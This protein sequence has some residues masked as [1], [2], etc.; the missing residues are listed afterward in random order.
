MARCV[1]PTATS[2]SASTKMSAVIVAKVRMMVLTGC[3]SAS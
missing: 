1:Q 3:P 2:Q